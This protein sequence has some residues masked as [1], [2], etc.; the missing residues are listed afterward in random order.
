MTKAGSK[1]F[2]VTMT[3]FSTPTDYTAVASLMK[4][5]LAQIGINVNIVPQD[6]VT[7]GANNSAGIVRLEPDRSRDAR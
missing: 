2:D 6:P 5:D 1:G 7:F 4:N 3:T